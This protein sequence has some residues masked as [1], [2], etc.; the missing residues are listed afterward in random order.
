MPDF[1]GDSM[2][3]TFTQ[4]YEHF[5]DNIKNG[6]LMNEHKVEFMPST[7]DLIISLLKFWN[8]YKIEGGTISYFRQLQEKHG[9]T[10]KSFWDEYVE[11]SKTDFMFS[12]STSLLL[13]QF[14]SA[15]VKMKCFT[16]IRANQ[17]IDPIFSGYFGKYGILMKEN[18]LLENGG[19]PVIYV[20]NSMN[21]TNIL[22]RNL[23]I[24]RTLDDCVKTLTKISS[25]SIHGA[26]FDLMSFVETSANRYEYEWRVASGHSLGGES[27]LPKIDRLKFNLNDVHSFYVP[28]E[29]AKKETLQFLKAV[30]SGSSHIP[31]VY[32]TDEIVLTDRDLEQIDKIKSRKP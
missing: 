22:G 14:K 2:F 21:L 9:G 19:C 23:S 30:D 7:H 8:E 32:L 3:I 13:G 29:S 26:F 4:K 25:S 28:D 24:L 10:S 11:R 1:R 18:W 15:P 6:F 16:E 31:Y 17:K 12:A 20:S 5:M 27:Y